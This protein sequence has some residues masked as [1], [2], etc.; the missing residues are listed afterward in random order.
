[1]RKLILSLSVT[2]LSLSANAHAHF[3]LTNP[4][5]TSGDPSGKGN[6]PCGPDGSATMPMAVTGGGVLKI[7]VDE[8]VPHTGFYR[9]ALSINSR[10]ELPIDNVV[11]DAKGKVLPP[12]GTPSGQSAT[13]DFEA[14]PVFPVL[15]DHLWV[16]DG[17]VPQTFHTELTLP[18]VTC[19]KCT[20]QVIEF[21]AVHGFNTSNP[22]PGGGYFYHHCADLKITAD[23]ALPPF[24]AGGAGGAGGAPGAG[25]G[26]ASAGA[27][28]ASTAGVGA[29]TAGAGASTAGAG[30]DSGGTGGASSD[31]GGSAMGGTLGV[32]GSPSSAGSSLT[33]SSGSGTVTGSNS[34]DNSGCSL[35]PR[36]SSAKPGLAVLLGLLLL[37]RRRRVRSLRG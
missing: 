11:K 34:E 23:P 5:S 3:D 35:T 29:S 36:S 19:A 2:L 18:N 13:A 6:P 17:T 24:G 4:S 31:V 37:G 12:S 1:M 28:G 22:G 30:G 7:D 9:I 14:T 26:G 10:S 33:S 16:H 20:L 25:A 27:A 8:T 32:S 15:A 21:M